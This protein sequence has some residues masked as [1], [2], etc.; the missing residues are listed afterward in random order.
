[1][2][3]AAQKGTTESNS[4]VDEALPPLFKYLSG[5]VKHQ[6]SGL[7]DIAVQMYSSILRTP[8]SRQLFWE[9]KDQTVAPLFDVLRSA[10]GVTKDANS[11]LWSGATSVRGSDGGLSG[12]LGIQLFYHIILVIWQLSF[13]AEKIGEQLE[14]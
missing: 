2:I 6:D 10:V 8:K 5:L 11:T 1:M 3:A 4:K 9:Q 7:Q 14:E 12:G 13:E